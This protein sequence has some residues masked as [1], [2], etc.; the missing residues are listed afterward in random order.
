MGLIHIHIILPPVL[1]PASRVCYRRI[2]LEIKLNFLQ[3]IWACSLCQKRQQILAKTGKWFQQGQADERAA[4]PSGSASSRKVSELKQ[5][6]TDTPTPPP[7]AP[8]TP[9]PSSTV[10]FMLH[11]LECFPSGSKKYGRPDIEVLQNHWD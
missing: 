1:S 4:T 2:R 10:C 11:L 6:P 7:S 8:R 9:L 3:T 5:S